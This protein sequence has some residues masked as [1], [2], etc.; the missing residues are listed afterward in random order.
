MKSGSVQKDPD[1]SIRTGIEQKK[2]EAQSTSLQVAAIA[3]LRVWP[4]TG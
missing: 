3:R 4:G 2:R 1:T